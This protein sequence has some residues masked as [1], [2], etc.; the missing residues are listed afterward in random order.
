MFFFVYTITYMCY[1]VVTKN[2]ICLHD[3]LRY[4]CQP[5]NKVLTTHEAFLEHENTV[6]KDLPSNEHKPAQVIEIW[7]H[8]LM[9]NY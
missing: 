1:I 9:Q 2:Y 3:S 7:C 5:C 8:C 6:H 4:L